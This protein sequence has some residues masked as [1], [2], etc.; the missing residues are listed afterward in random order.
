MSIQA[1][2]TQGREIS[3]RAGVLDG[4]HG[5]FENHASRIHHSMQQFGLNS[6]Q[7]GHLLDVCPFFAYVPFLLKARTTSCQVLEGNDPSVYPLMPLY[8]ER[9]IRFDFVDMHELFGPVIEASHRLPLEDASFDTVLCWETMEH[10]S[11]NPV[12]FVREL[13]RILRPG[14]RIHITVPNRASF[15]NLASLVFGRGEASAVEGYFRFEHTMTNGRN[16]FY[17][18]HW[19]EYTP[20]ELRNLFTQAGLKVLSC[21]TFTAFQ[22]ADRKSALRRFARGMSSAG[23]RLLPRYG[24]NV[25]LTATK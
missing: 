10:F 7:L 4:L 2:L 3:A 11:F 20:G 18:F 25:F 6:G 19:R 8:G 1:L 21:G 16:V 13:G 15:Q 5:Y 24:T 17:G 22:G 12:K 23:S 9:G 14:G